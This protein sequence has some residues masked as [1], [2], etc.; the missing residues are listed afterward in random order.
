MSTLTSKEEATVIGAV[1]TRE[2]HRPPPS[3][4]YD[5]GVATRSA[6]T[7]SIYR[8]LGAGRIEIAVSPRAVRLTIEGAP[9]PARDS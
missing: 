1:T 3:R 8:A 6:L 9:P 7:A 4:D 5:S 2:D